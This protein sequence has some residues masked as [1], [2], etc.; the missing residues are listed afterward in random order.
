MIVDVCTLMCQEGEADGAEE[1]VGGSDD[2]SGDDSEDPETAR[3][4]LGAAVDHSL[5]P[6]DPVG[7][8][9]FHCSCGSVACQTTLYPLL[10]T[11]S[12][13]E[14][15]RQEKSHLGLG[16]LPIQIQPL[17]QPHNLVT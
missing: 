2:G 13:R 1:G 9:A 15:G 11:L 17:C 3:L 14:V 8:H 16:V 5:Q 12:P 6:A 10:P 4:P 7:L